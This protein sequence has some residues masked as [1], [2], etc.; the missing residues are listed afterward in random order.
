MDEIF[1][2]LGKD[3]SRR[4]SLA[5]LPDMTYLD[6]VVFE[7]LRLFPPV[8]TDEKQAAKDDVLPNGEPIKAGTNVYY[9]I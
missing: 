7:T 6:A 2:F 9:D 8:P 5:M 1:N 4:V 3:L